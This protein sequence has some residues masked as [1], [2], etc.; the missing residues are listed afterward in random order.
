MQEFPL[1]RHLV[2]KQALPHLHRALCDPEP[3]VRAEAARGLGRVGCAD[4]MPILSA[5]LR[6]PD[7]DVRLAVAAAVRAIVTRDAVRAPE[8]E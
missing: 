1:H 3:V 4:C 5:C 6:D 7:S 2:E 8:L